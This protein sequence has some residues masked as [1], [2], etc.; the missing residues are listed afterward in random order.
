MKN[1]LMPMLDK[2][3]LR[4]RFMIETFFDKLKSSMGLEHNRHRS[5]INALVHILSC[6]AA[7]TLAQPKVKIGNIGIPNT[8]PS[9]T[10][11]S[12]TYPELGLSH[13]T[14]DCVCAGQM[15]PRA[16]HQTAPSLAPCPYLLSSFGAE[17]RDDPSSTRWGED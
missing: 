2:V 5:P 1:D 10:S 16:G 7:Y 13:S 3:L 11:S 14:H 9:I 4:K 12:S 15:A 6:L 8:I 17:A